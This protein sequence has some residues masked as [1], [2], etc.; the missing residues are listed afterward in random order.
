[1]PLDALPYQEQMEKF[2]FIAA[3]HAAPKFFPVKARKLYDESGKELPGWLRIVR[4]DTEQTLHVATDKY[5]VV[6]NEEAFGAFEEALEKSTLDR[7]NMR[8]GTDYAGGGARC[9]RQYLLPAHRVEVKTG[10]E[11]ALRLLMMNSY[12][13][14]LKFRGQCGAYNF[15]C[16]NTSISGTDYAQ[17]AARHTGKIDVRAAIEGLTKAA[18]EHVETTRRWAEWPKIGVTDQ[19]AMAVC[20]TMPLATD[21][22]VD[23][24]VHS[25]IRARDGGGPQ[26]GANVW[27]LFN[28]LTQWAS[29]VGM[30]QMIKGGNGQSRYEREKR[31]A[32][33]IEGK[34]WR[35]LA[36]A[37]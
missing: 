36:E 20:K 21:G 6:T 1:M 31:V 15:V 33:L 34:V 3:D 18:E 37:A 24:L 17:F 22:L 9:F 32:K 16:A 28:V 8:I 29:H 35:E 12:D 7:T 4:E 10:V 14:S 5:Q 23:N 27:T 13:G 30:D 26:S 11:V 25:W 19:Q 2:G